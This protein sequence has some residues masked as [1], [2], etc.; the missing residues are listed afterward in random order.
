MGKEILNRLALYPNSPCH[1]CLVRMT[2]T[3]SAID[4]TICKD[5][6]D[7]ILNLIKDER[8]K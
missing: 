6:I 3:T 4:K 2:C 8:N 1:K 7:Y 5:F